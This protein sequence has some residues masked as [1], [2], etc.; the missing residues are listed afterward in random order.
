MKIKLMREL[1][2]VAYYIFEDMTDAYNPKE[3]GN[4]FWDH[5]RSK[6]LDGT[7]KKIKVTDFIYSY[8]RKVNPKHYKQKYGINLSKIKK[9]KDQLTFVSELITK[10]LKHSTDTSLIDW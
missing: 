3:I 5:V 10:M 8:L 7:T 4:L 9:S 6:T 2:D 1:L